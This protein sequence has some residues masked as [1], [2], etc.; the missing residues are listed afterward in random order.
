MT[1]LG[2]VPEGSGN[3]FEEVVEVDLL[4]ID[5]DGSRLDLREIENVADEVQ[6]IGAGAVDRARKLDL[7]GR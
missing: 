1:P 7:L 2:L 6:E 4:R 5:R 3:R